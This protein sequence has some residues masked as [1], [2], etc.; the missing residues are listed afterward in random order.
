[1]QDAI[2][3]F[4]AAEY[5]R[6]PPYRTGGPNGRGAQRGNALQGVARRKSTFDLNFNLNF[7]RTTS[8]QHILIN[9]CC[10][11][12]LSQRKRHQSPFT[13]TTWVKKRVRACV[14]A[15]GSTILYWAVWRA[16]RGS[17]T[18][19]QHDQ[20][21]SREKDPEPT[22]PEA[23]VPLREP[24]PCNQNG[25]HSGTRRGPMEANNIQLQLTFNPSLGNNMARSS[26]I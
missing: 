2:S 5:L 14:V 15:A 3:C 22:H 25:L 17:S 6:V 8:Q 20:I 19:S 13:S 11:S 18:A 26:S 23:R 12:K 16:P 21:R 9:T 1:M 7:E 4:R 10:S 24:K